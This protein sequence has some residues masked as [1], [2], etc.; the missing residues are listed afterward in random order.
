MPK[1]DT[2]KRRGPG[3]PPKGKIKI[4]FKLAPRIATALEKARDMTGR[5][6]SQLAEEA[7]IEY[8]PLDTQEPDRGSNHE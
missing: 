1:K 3:G 5:D 8:L 4:T 7:L 6:K 2:E